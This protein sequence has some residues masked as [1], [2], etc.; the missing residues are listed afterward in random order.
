VHSKKGK[1]F[2]S[3][4]SVN[5]N[6]G[7]MRLCAVFDNPE[8]VLRPGQYG[9]VRSVM[10]I[11]KDAIVIPQRAV[12]ELQ[13]IQ[14]VAVVTADNKAS[15]RTVKAGPQIGSGW[16]IE[17]GLKAGDKVVV[18]GFLKIRD[19]LPVVAVPFGDAPAAE[20]KPEAAPAKDAK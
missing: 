2:A 19:G 16:L 9:R 14:Q 3:D 11:V 17:E 13:G 6:T 18:E 1:F 12:N 5:A 7:S 4:V 8:N 15:I 10:K 20:K